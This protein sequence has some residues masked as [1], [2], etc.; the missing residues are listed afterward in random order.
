LELQR[1]ALE[2]KE[3]KE[4]A[5]STRRKQE[6]HIEMQLLKDKEELDLAIVEL[7]QLSESDA[8]LASKLN[9]IPNADPKIRTAEFIFKVNKRSL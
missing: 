5:K 9:D 2:E 7:E 8:N 1:V 4:A 6:L 3:K